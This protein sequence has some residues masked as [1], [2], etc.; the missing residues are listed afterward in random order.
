MIREIKLSDKKEVLQISSQISDVDYKNVCWIS[1]IE[2]E[3]EK[4][5][6]NY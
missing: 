3:N 1:L 4:Y 6:K 5:M 2:T